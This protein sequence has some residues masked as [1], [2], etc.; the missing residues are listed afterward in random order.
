MRGHCGQRNRRL[1]ARGHPRHWGGDGHLLGRRGS[2]RGRERNGAESQSVASCLAAASAPRPNALRV[3]L[4]VPMSWEHS[5]PGRAREPTRVSARLGDGLLDATRVRPPHAS[6]STRRGLGASLRH[7]GRQQDAALRFSSSCF[8]RALLPGRPA[9]PFPNAIG[10][11]LRR[12]RFPD[13]CPRV[14]SPA[15]AV[16]GSR[17]FERRPGPA[18]VPGGFILAA[19]WPGSGPCAQGA[20]LRSMCCFLSCSAGARQLHRLGEWTPAPIAMETRSGL[21]KSSQASVSPLRK[22][23]GRGD[24][25]PCAPKGEAVG[26]APG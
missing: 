15:V 6:H 13:R 26:M 7:R 5:E 21:G 3:P 16:C 9:L 1:T 19:R 14:R 25:R 17:G 10:L 4:R 23:G 20:G 18:P 24:I 11:E 8:R 22:R 2:G 12:R